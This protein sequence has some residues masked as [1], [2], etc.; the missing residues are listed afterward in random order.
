MRLAAICVAL[1]LCL[2]LS[3]L[4]AVWYPEEWAGPLLEPDELEGFE[5]KIQ[6]IERLQFV[7]PARSWNWYNQLYQKV[8]MDPQNRIRLAL[9]YMVPRLVRDGRK[10][11]LESLQA[12]EPEIERLGESPFWRG[13]LALTRGDLHNRSG[14]PDSAYAEYLRAS[15]YFLRGGHSDWQSVALLRQARMRYHFG[16]DVGV[17]EQLQSIVEREDACPSIRAFAELFLIVH[18]ASEINNEDGRRYAE[19]IN[20]LRGKHD[21][22][23]DGE[24]LAFEFSRAVGMSSWI[25]A[26]RI[27]LDLED[28][29]GEKRMRWFGAVARIQRVALEL[30]YGLADS[31]L[32]IQKSVPREVAAAGWPGAL[33]PVLAAQGEWALANGQLEF[34]ESAFSEARDY[35]T[36]EMMLYLEPDLQWGMS[37]IARARGDFFQAYDYYTAFKEASDRR[38]SYLMRE[39]MELQEEE[40][41]QDRLALE[42]SLQDFQVQQAK[43][44]RNLTIIGFVL[45]L[46]VVVLLWMR[47]RLLAVSQSNLKLAVEKQQLANDHAF[48]AQ[49]AA[50]A[51]NRLKTEFL[52]NISHEVKTPLNAL[53]GMIS[54]L[55]EMPAASSEQKR[56]L[57]T[58]Q[59]C[60]DKL[61]KLLNDIIDLGKMES[62][63]FELDWAPFQPRKT[64][65]ECVQIMQPTARAK[66]LQLDVEGDDQLPGRAVGDAGRISQV[67]L[68]LL[69]N[70]IKFTDTGRVHLRVRFEPT[71]TSGGWLKIAVEDTGIGVHPSYSERIFRPFE[72]GDG[73]STR[74]HGGSGLGLAICQ[75]L[76]RMMEGEISFTSEPGK[77]SCFK[78]R[79]RLH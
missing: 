72:Q 65:A 54:V 19:A 64:L 28:H 43:R 8:G 53:I 24:L 21:P 69:E 41:E 22:V 14:F 44:I 49:Q 40:M 70:A 71:K 12:L 18:Q 73:S 17:Q 74:R 10:A 15:R 62:G 76:V 26:E 23:F 63:R 79:M 78:V 20:Y 67:L 13:R 47:L 5:E 56:C 11:A 55:Q 6:A 29:A 3:T 50:E 68:N 61:S 30:S 52:S 25:Q 46:I 42:V 31:A 2:T 7:D 37:Q 48:S 77:G 45:A 66:G 60:S 9:A 16:S 38:L 1:G 51:A 59:S 32:E 58:I 57:E 39:Q 75:H 33:T 27:L 34:A 36:N 35:A 4:K